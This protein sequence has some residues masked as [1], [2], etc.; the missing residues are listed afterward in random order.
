[1]A[2]RE[3]SMTETEWLSSSDPE[4]MLTVVLPGASERKLRLFACACARCFWDDFDHPRSR[5]AVETTERYAD[6]L[7]DEREHRSAC[8]AAS[9]VARA[10]RWET[11]EE[12]FGETGRRYR[13]RALA[14]AVAQKRIRFSVAE[15]VRT[16]LQLAYDDDRTGVVR[17]RVEGLRDRLSGLLRDVFGNSFAAA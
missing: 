14:R 2:Q 1:M 11:S 12:W 8:D 17:R 3:V 10:V 7:T 6:G 13:L 9:A 5:L 16:A 15:A 4:A